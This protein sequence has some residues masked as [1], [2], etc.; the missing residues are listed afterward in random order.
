M[1]VTEKRPLVTFMR[2][3]VGA[4]LGR[5]NTAMKPYHGL[6]DFLEG[7][8]LPVISFIFGRTAY[9]DAA[10]IFGGT[11]EIGDFSGAISAIRTLVEG[12]TVEIGSQ[13]FTVPRLD[14]LS[15]EA[16]IGIGSFTIDGA[17]AAVAR[18][19][20]LD[21]ETSNPRAFGRPDDAATADTIRV[22][23]S[24]KRLRSSRLFEFRYSR[25]QSRYTKVLSMIRMA[26]CEY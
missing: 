6:V 16:W 1:K 2:D 23:P 13:S 15:G 3:F 24:K 8:A 17:D 10:Q 22:G 26:S 14:S 18:T 19:A 11:A 21:P 7:D 20:P 12:G 5:V 25:W 9:L 4:T